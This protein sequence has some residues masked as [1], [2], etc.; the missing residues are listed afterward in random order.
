[1]RCSVGSSVTSFEHES[2]E[3]AIGSRSFKATGGRTDGRMWVTTK[4]HGRACS[5]VALLVL[6]FT[7]GACGPTGSGPSPTTH[8]HQPATAQ[9]PVI[10][11][12]TVPGPTTTGVGPTTTVVIE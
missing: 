3:R 6:G 4:S 11:N 8:R 7:L 9:P 12:T 5:V 2:T 10:T 1:M